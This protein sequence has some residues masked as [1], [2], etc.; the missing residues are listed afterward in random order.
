M[1]IT[2]I[3]LS[4]LIAILLL[5]GCYCDAPKTGLI[6]LSASARSWINYQDGQTI[7]FKASNGQTDMLQVIHYKDTIE[8]YFVGDECPDGMKEV[9]RAIITNTGLKDT[10]TIELESGRLNVYSKGLGFNK[11]GIGLTYLIDEKVIFPKDQPENYT[12]LER[13]DLV[14][15]SFAQVLKGKCITCKQETVTEVYLAKGLGLIGFVRNKEL[16]I[17]Q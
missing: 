5:N 12:F 13:V 7:E 14:G 16:W 4:V 6:K 9:I 8:N 3:T 17:I 2:K 10:I 15:N 1:K 11:I